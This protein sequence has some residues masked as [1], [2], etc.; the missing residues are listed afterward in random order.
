MRSDVSELVINS[1]QEYDY[2]RELLSV[3]TPHLAE[4]VKLIE[5]EYDLLER[6]NLNKQLS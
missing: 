1:R 3:S 5:N 2:I 4:K 6:Y